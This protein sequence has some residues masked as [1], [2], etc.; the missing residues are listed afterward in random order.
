MAKLNGELFDRAWEFVKAP[1]LVRLREFFEVGEGKTFSTIEERTEFL[2]NPPGMYGR[3]GI[4]LLSTAVS[5]DEDGSHK[6]IVRYL[7]EIGCPVTDALAAHGYYERFEDVERAMEI[8]SV[9]RADGHKRP[10]GRGV[11][12]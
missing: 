9:D 10:K 8:N 6:E 3:L 1:D 2:E 4:N 12:E 7:R 5:N 11:G